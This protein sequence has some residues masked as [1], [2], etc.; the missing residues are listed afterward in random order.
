MHSLAVDGG[1]RVFAAWLDERNI[2]F[3]D[4]AKNPASPSMHHEQKEPN[5]EVYYSISRDGGKTF[6][7][8]KKI[9][10][11]VCPCC[12]TAVLAAVDGTVYVSW[13]QVLKDDF[14]HIAVSHSN[15]G[16]ETFSPGV[17]VSDDRWQI[18]ACPVSGA[19][20]ASGGPQT[21][22][23]LWYSGGTE[24]D[25]GIYFARSDDG[26]NTFGERKLVDDNAIGGTP[27]LLMKNATPTAVFAGADEK[28]YSVETKDPA[29]HVEPAAIT[30]GALPSATYLN[31]KIAT[32]FVRNTNSSSE[33]WFV[34]G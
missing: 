19:T 14:R 24:G 3:E 21:L 1:G 28:I 34:A 30:T 9:A 23:V 10:T 12:K 13:R 8:N 2:K 18:N 22:E 7:T 15:D 16:G 17:I 33:V 5:S 25:L 31:G 29:N 32:A 4:H 26:G 20:M 11:D 6:L 27:V